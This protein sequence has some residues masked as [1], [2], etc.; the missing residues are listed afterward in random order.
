MVSPL[1]YLAAPASA[2][3]NTNRISTESR[4]PRARKLT[5]SGVG[6]VDVLV[7][8]LLSVSVRSENGRVSVK[9]VDLLERQ[10]LGL[11]NEEVGEEEAERA[12]RSPA[13]YVSAL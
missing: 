4:M 5:S 10:S 2:S 8:D 9:D 12:T 13:K 11:G 1:P 3:E 7:E 6:V